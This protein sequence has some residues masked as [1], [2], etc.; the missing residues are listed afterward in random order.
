MF[1]ALRR[2]ISDLLNPRFTWTLIK[3]VLLSIVAYASVWGAAWWLIMRSQWAATPWL[4]QSLHVLGGLGVMVVSLL[5]FPSVFGVVQAIFIDG[6]ADRV[7]GKHY[8]QLGEPRGAAVWDGMMVGLNVLLLMVVVNLVMLPVY[9]IGTLFFG[10]GMLIFYA[11]NGWL[12][13]REYFMQV[14]L[15]RMPRPETKLWVRANR[16]TL[17]LA[18]IAITLVGTVPLLNLAAPVIGCV[19]MVHISRTLTP[20]AA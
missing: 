1:A 10:A 8:P 6:I 17:W 2:T 15:R 19:F 13:G 4:N 20:P 9:I 3:A 7:E 5:L 18:G 12:C 11:V 16:K 14:A